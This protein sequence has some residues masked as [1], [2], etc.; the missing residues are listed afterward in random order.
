MGYKWNRLQHLIKTADALRAQ[1]ALQDWVVLKIDG[2]NFVCKR[3][4]S[5]AQRKAAAKSGAAMSDGSYPIENSKDL[6]NAISLAGMSSH[7][8]SAVKAHI[9]ARAKA[10]G[11]EG[12]L[13]KDWHE[14]KKEELLDLRGPIEKAPTRVEDGL[15]EGKGKPEIK[16]AGLNVETGDE[17]KHGIYEH[18]IA[19]RLI[20]HTAKVVGDGTIAWTA[21]PQKGPIKGKFKTHEDAK[22]YLA[23]THGTQ[24]GEEDRE[25][26]ES[27]KKPVKKFELADIQTGVPGVVSLLAFRDRVAK[28]EQ[29]GLVMKNWDAANKWWAAHGSSGSQSN[30]DEMSDH[31]SSQAEEHEA[32]ADRIDNSGDKSKYARETSNAHRDAASAHYEAAKAHLLVEDRGEDD[33]SA[34]TSDAVKASKKAYAMS[35]RLKKAETDMQ[36]EDMRGVKKSEDKTGLVMKAAT[37]SASKAAQKAS[38][39][40]YQAQAPDIQQPDY[41]AAQ[42]AHMAAAQ[43]HDTAD[44]AHQ[45][46]AQKSMDASPKVGQ[47]HLQEARYHFNAAQ[48]HRS[49]ARDIQDRQASMG[50]VTA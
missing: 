30:H 38:V 15:D 44:Q 24:L 5:D 4:F 23:D 10:L 47:A 3:D 45:A 22:Q 35:E 39:E 18:K 33:A 43:A 1:P 16:K 31:H 37:V 41:A 49:A 34:H 50:N 11:L 28:A 13:P 29:L 19:G 7:S 6:H 32:E 40:A 26:A 36:I 8:K 42:Q 2:Q 21:V 27:D 46:E 20:G 9:K 12:E 48:A 25:K 14:T 17:P